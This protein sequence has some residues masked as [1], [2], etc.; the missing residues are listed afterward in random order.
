MAIREYISEEWHDILRHNHVDDFERLWALDAEN[1]FEPPNHRRGGWSGVVRTKLALPTGGEAHIFIKRQENHV[2]RAWQNLFRLT[3]TFEREFRNLLRFRQFGIPSPETIYFGQRT[4]EGKLRAILVTRELAGYLPVNAECYSPIAK[5]DRS[6]RKLLISQAADT[7]RRLHQ[8]RIQ[9]N[10]LYPK[11][12]FVREDGDF[13]VC[14]IDLEKAKWRPYKQSIV[15]RD[16]G[17]LYRHTEGWSRTDQLR[18]FLAYRN[19][20][21]ASKK[22]KKILMRI[23]HDGSPAKSNSKKHSSE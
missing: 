4:V 20:S 12:L 16:F 19:E 3:A 14:L 9:H 18:L 13:E 22:S 7:V 23:F 15:V 21:R 6:R 17:S 11:H 5:L 2:Y 1:W 10:C 8:K